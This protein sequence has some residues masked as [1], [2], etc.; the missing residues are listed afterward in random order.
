[1]DWFI[2][3]FKPYSPMWPSDA[4]RR[5]QAIIWTNVKFSSMMFGGIHMGAISE[6]IFLDVHLK[7]SNST[8]GGLV[9][10]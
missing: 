5:H 9:T 10:L 8:H 1:M 6:N 3:V 4:K 7:I 2:G